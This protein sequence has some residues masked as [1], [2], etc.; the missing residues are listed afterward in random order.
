MI[1]LR[2]LLNLIKKGQ[3]PQKIIYDYIVYEYKDGKY[4][5]R[6]G[7]P[8]TIGTVGKWLATEKNIEVIA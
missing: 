7:H 1:T 2:E 3:A 5:D 6:F 4:Y 8:W